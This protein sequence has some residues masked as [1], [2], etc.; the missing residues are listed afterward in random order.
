M[1][2]GVGVMSDDGVTRQSVETDRLP[3]W[4]NKAGK[5]LRAVAYILG[6]VTA[7]VIAGIALWKALPESGSNLDCAHYA[8]LSPG[9]QEKCD[10][11]K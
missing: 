3:D 5:F 11:A 4:A 1:M 9:D 7:V 10:T 2:A 6:G 8:L